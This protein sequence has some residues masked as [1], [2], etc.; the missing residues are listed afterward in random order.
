MP[1]INSLLDNIAQI[2]KSG[3]TKPTLLSKLDLRYAYSQI[4]LDQKTRKQ[5]NFNLIGSNA[6]GTY[7]FQ[8]G[9]YGLT[10]MPA[11]FQKAIDLTLANCLNTYAYLHDIL[12]V[13]KG[14]TELDQQKLKAVLD[15][16]DEENLAISLEK[17]KFACKQIE[18]LGFNNNS[19]G[20][21]PLTKK[22]EAIEKLS[23]PKTF[24]QL[25][26]FMGSKHHLTQYISNLAQ[27]AAALRPLLKTQK[28]KKN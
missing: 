26:R 21:T 25:K 19:E 16:L 22:T 7:Q 10:D 12:I 8:T 4:P 24:K 20:K 11:E 3:K 5:G 15:R 23:A 2:V 9:F 27:A 14:S 6:T 17:C 13:S 28:R 18:R 1:N